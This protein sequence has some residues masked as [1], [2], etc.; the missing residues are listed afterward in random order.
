M[1]RELLEQRKLPELMKM[2]DGRDVARETWRER[3]EEILALL[4]EY[5]YGRMPVYQGKTTAKVESRTDAAAGKAVTEVVKIT[6]PTPDGES[7]SFPVSLT[8]PK[9]ASAEAPAPA[10]VF[11]SF[12]FPMYYPMEEIVDNGVIVAEF[13]MN[14]VAPDCEDHYEG[15]MAPHYIKDGRRDG[16]AFGKIGMWAFAASRVL[17][18]LLT[19]DT[20]DK[21]RVGVMG[22]SRLGKTALWAGANDER[23][24]HVFSNDSG[25]SGAALTR[26]KVGETFPRI[27]KVFPYWFCE[28][29]QEISASIEASE[30]TPFDQHF[31]L[32]AVAPRKVYV[33]SAMEDAWADPYSEF[34]A[35]HAASPAWE[36]LGQKGFLAPNRLPVEDEEFTEGSI[37][38][39]LRPGT[40]FLSRYDWIRYIRF[41]KGENWFDGSF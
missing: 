18:Y 7:F 19:L 3:R 32:A 16:V 17:D 28:T 14:D 13:V 40:H 23:F 9:T 21:E 30:Q 35:C 37:G 41:L 31:L 1:V 4:A 27:A 24:T 33:A 34:L 11:I 10:F 25:C 38:Y 36:L 15:G 12:G 20:V 2:Q 22:H 29:M 26:G 39:H 5:Q 8:V 6:F